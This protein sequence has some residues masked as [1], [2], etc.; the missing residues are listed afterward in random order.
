MA[1]AHP[2]NAS[3]P[4]IEKTAVSCYAIP[5]ETPESDGTLAVDTIGLS[6]RNSFID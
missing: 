4:L 1:I 6:T 3:G 2:M 5:T